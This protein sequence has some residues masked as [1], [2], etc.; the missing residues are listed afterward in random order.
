M[1]K[2][3]DG[4][5]EFKHSGGLYR[6]K[7]NIKE[8][9]EKYLQDKNEFQHKGKKFIIDGI[10]INTNSEHF[11]FAVETYEKH[12]E[13]RCPLCGTKASHF[14][15]VKSNKKFVLF[16]FRKAENKKVTYYHMFNIDHIVPISKGGSNK[17]NNKQLVCIRCNRLKANHINI[18]EVKK[19]VYNHIMN[20]FEKNLNINSFKR[21]ERWIA[22]SCIDKLKPVFIELI[23]KEYRLSKET[24]FKNF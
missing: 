8:V 23:S 15:L 22:Q 13:I 6:K 5:K 11:Q 16:G 3:I 1:K 14:R 24:N 12:G 4:T 21:N 2:F 18:N 20:V 7:Y 17:K 9:I 10:E 19:N